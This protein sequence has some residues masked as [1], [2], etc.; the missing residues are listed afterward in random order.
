MILTQLKI[1]NFRNLQPVSLRFHPN[2]NFIYG[3]N[4][5]GKTSILEAIF[6]LANAKSF[7]TNKISHVIQQGQPSVTVFSEFT[8]LNTQKQ[9]IAYQYGKNDKSVVKH[10]GKKSKYS[11]IIQKL[12][13]LEIGPRSTELFFSG[14]QYR[15]NVLNWGVFHVE[16]EFYTIW[17]L[18]NRSL[19][20]RNILLKEASRK[21]MS[22][23]DKAKLLRGDMQFDYWTAQFVKT[24]EILDKYRSLYM[25]NLEFVIQEILCELTE[26][27]TLHESI[28][29]RYRTGWQNE[30][31]LQETLNNQLERD[32]LSG[33][34]SSGFHR[35]DF[36]PYSNKKPA[37][38]VLSRGQLKLL[39]YALKLAQHKY[40]H[41][42]TTLS[43]ICL[44]D[45]IGSELDAQ[46]Y[47]NVMH[48]LAQYSMQVIV[49]SIFENNIEELVQNYKAFHV[50]HGQISERLNV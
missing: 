4:G 48:W 18:A 44:L 47:K 37:H 27:K 34:T 46:H 49:T 38:E 13:I 28:L 40:M 7:R 50:E 19:K 6:L 23:N 29:L 5:A 8:D 41:A 9:T 10:N 36:L 33:Y 1:N 17:K 43:P 22:L 32:I 15:R 20:Q 25:L 16:H 31:S 3:K 42:K 14:P 45:D 39:I 21:H 11:T 2:I 24:S 30:I 26:D 35:A 12:A